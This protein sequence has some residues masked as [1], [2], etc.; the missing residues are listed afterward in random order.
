MGA[1]GSAMTEQPMGFVGSSAADFAGAAYIPQQAYAPHF[2]F[3]C[4]GLLAL[5]CSPE[6]PK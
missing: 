4:V 3:R 2:A 1:H 6:S 5:N